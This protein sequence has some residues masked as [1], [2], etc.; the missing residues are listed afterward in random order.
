MLPSCW[1]WP[2]NPSMTKY[3]SGTL[4][5]V[6]ARRKDIA[7]LLGY[8]FYSTSQGPVT[9]ICV[10]RMVRAKSTAACQK[11]G[12]Q[13]G[14][15]PGTVRL[16]PDEIEHGSFHVHRTVHAEAHIFDAGGGIGAVL[17]VGRLVFGDEVVRDL[18]DG[19]ERE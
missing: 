19:G 15:G 1:R 6:I 8:T 4:Q 5:S 3:V 10:S 17:A 13:A 18:L 2:A 16:V 11:V 7:E 9:S 14:E 12:I